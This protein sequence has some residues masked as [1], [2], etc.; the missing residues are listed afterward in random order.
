M[1]GVKILYGAGT[2]GDVDPGASDWYPQAADLLEKHGVKAIDTAELYAGSEAELGKLGA[3][4]RFSIDSKW[5]GG[6]AGPDEATDDIVAHAKESL[7]RLGVSSVDVYYV[8]LPPNVR[9]HEDIVEAMQQ[10]HVA[11]KIKRFGLSNFTAEDVEKIHTLCTQKG[12]ILPSVYEGHYSAVGRKQETL[13]FPTLRKLGI[14]FYSYS[15]LGGGFLAKTKEQV[16]GGHGRYDTSS[17]FGQMFFDMFAKPE[18]LEILG[19]WGEIA[20]EAGCS[21]AQ[22]GLRWLRYHSE[23]SEM[24]GDGIIIGASSLKQ[25]EESLQALDAGPLDAHVSKRV[26]DIWPKVEPTAWQDYFHR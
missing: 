25:L 16:L 13:L 10:L 3:P 7:T 9:T 23:L 8:H 15:P 1:S 4:K 14:A 2:I 12:Y 20:K 19:E 21:R 5:R 17:V 11:G 22:L 18:A 6:F 24:H 26:D